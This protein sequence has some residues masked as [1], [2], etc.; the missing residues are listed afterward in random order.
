MSHLNA[1]R[2]I[3]DG[4]DP[5]GLIVEDDAV[6]HPARATRQ[7]LAATVAQLPASFT[8]AWLGSCPHLEMGGVSELPRDRA[9][10]NGRGAPRTP[11][12]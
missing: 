7:L 3:A 2:E 1:W 8:V 12:W 11:T 9:L 10:E 4:D 6:L 5:Y